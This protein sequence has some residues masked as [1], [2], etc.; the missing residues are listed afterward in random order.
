MGA[1]L[2]DDQIERLHIEYALT[3][4]VDRAAKAAGVSWAAAK[5]YLSQPIDPLT[6]LS[7]V[8]EQKKIDI[9][10]KLGDLQVV[11]IEALMRDEKIAKASFQELAN[12]LG[13]ATEK[14]QLITG[15]ATE[16]HEHRDLDEPRQ[17]LASRI[18]E[19][20]ARRRANDDSGRA[21][22]VGS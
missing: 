7:Q 8:R 15:Q 11:L 2:S 10:A 6:P 5:K 19:L 12:T 16:R 13:I 21:A 18:D 20:A 22:A 1:A 17:H 4:K 9:A 3:R 14:R